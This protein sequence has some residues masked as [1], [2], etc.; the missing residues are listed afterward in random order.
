[1]VT[2]VGKTNFPFLDEH[3]IYTN[4]KEKIDLCE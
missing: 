2:I 1:M 4:V 3:D